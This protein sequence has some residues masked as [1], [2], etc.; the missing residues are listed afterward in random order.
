M[1]RN[2]LRELNKAIAG[3]SLIEDAPTKTIATGKWGCGAFKGDPQLKFLIQWMAASVL[4]RKLIFHT[5][6]DN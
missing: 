4:G 6:Q 3:F 5:F 2:L 1:V